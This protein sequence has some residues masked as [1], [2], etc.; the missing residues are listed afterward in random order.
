MIAADMIIP[1]ECSGR[2]R[3]AFIRKGINAISCDL[4]ESETPGPHIIVKNDAELKEIVYSK[5]WLAV[6]SFPPCTRLTNAGYWYILKYDL[7]HEVKKA[8]GFFNMLLNA[9]AKFVL[10]EN[11]VQHGLA[12][13]YIRDYDQSVQPYNFMEN[14]SKRTCFWLKGLPP[15]KKT[16]FYPPRMVNGQALWNDQLPLFDDIDLSALPRW[17]NQTDSGQ[18]RKGQS[19]RRAADRSRTYAGIAAAMADQWAPLL[20]RAKNA[21]NE[22]TEYLQAALF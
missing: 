4:K 7:Q 10:T 17:D 22:A 14:A 1:C 6:F 11:P 2:V 3:D 12:R 16:G 19:K 8:A 21:S 9:P 5:E 15:L 18:D 20:H 13:Q